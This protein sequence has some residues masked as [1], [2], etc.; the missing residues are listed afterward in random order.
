MSG[1]GDGE[2]GSGCRAR[3]RGEFHSVKDRNRCFAGCG[4]VRG[5]SNRGGEWFLLGQLSR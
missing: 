2:L 1:R 4:V 5:K 3:G